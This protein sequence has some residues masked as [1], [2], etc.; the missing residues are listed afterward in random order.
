MLINPYLSQR[1]VGQLRDAIANLDLRLHVLPVILNRPIT[2][3]V[4]PRGMSHLDALTSVSI[5][6]HK[7]SGN[8]QRTACKSLTVIEELERRT[9]RLW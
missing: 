6:I 7:Q 9:P 2:L 4:H 1:V 5:G 3:G 8:R